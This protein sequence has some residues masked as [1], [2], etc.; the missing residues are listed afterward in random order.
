MLGTC[1][2]RN[3]L[4]DGDVTLSKQ[5]KWQKTFSLFIYEIFLENFSGLILIN[6]QRSH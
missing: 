6:A 5:S 4:F 1:N 2:V 3:I